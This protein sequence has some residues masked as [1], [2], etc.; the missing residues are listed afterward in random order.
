MRF[1][2][3]WLWGYSYRQDRTGQDRT[4][5][6]ETKGPI[7]E[8]EGS[9]PHDRSKV[10]EETVP[11]KASR[12]FFVEKRDPTTAAGLKPRHFFSEVKTKTRSRQIT[13]IGESVSLSFL[14]GE[15]T[16]TMNAARDLLFS[17]TTISYAG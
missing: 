14:G 12:S 6:R 9:A 13:S 8:T 17:L 2:R 10:L 1:L 15:E 11:R 16:R 4:L 5:G 7:S 3:W